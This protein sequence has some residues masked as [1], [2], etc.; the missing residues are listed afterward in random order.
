MSKT[1]RIATRNSP[2]ALWQA[3]FVKAQLLKHHPSLSIDIIGMTTRGDQIIDTPLTKLGGKGLF[4]KELEKAILENN[5]DI[6]VHSMK[7]VG[8]QCPPG[9]FIS[10]IMARHNPF[11]AFVSN[12]Y[13]S[14]DAMPPNS[15]VGSC[16]LRRICQLQKHYPQLQFTPL[17]GNVNTRLQKLDD[18]QYD[19]IILAAAGLERLQLTQRIRVEIPPEICLPAIAQGT[20]GIECRQSDQRLHE[21]LAVL[22]DT[23]NTI[24]ATAERTINARL[25]GSC[26]TPIAAYATLQNSP[27]NHSQQATRT[28]HLKALV[29]TP[30]GRLILSAAQ[31]TTIDADMTIDA[32]LEK[33]TTLGN[34][35]AASLVEQGA[36]EILATL[37]TP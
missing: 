28:L 32:L 5:A 21:M 11:D 6:A 3:N 17:R 27:T 10:T 16:S 29:G 34:A 9:L 36:A 33:A 20:I 4:V 15:I 13:A 2:L 25:Q 7:D 8:T 31:S 24:C 22:S 26:Q 37:S 18:Q 19:A 23:D 12:D 1:I 30:D 35:V 14:L